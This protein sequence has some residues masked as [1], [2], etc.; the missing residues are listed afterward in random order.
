MLGGG[1]VPVLVVYPGP[2]R[3]QMAWDSA[4][5]NDDERVAGRLPPG[6]AAAEI[7]RLA[8]EGRTAEAVVAGPAIAAMAA[9]AAREPRW[10]AVMMKAWQLAPT[11]AKA[12][13][14]GR[15]PGL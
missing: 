14:E 13:A 4:P 7:V 2:M 8:L 5:S 6:D 1:K 11:V 9:R 3:T 12:V 10:G 15:D